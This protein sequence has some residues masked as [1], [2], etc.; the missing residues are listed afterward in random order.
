MLT[1]DL[2]EKLKIVPTQPGVYLWKDADGVVIYVG[3]AKVLRNRVRSYHQDID[4]KDIKTR[5]M[6]SRAVDLDWMVTESEKAALIL[7]NTLIKKYRPR[8]N[9]LLRDDKNFLSIKLTVNETWPRL[10]LVRR[11]VRD[12]SV[13]FGPFSD[14]GAARATFGFLNRHFPLRECSDR[15]FASRERPCINYQIGRSAGPC[16]GKIEKADYDRIVKQVRLFFEG[17][18]HDL[19]KDLRVEMERAAEDLRFEQAARYRDLVDALTKTLNKQQAEAPYLFDRDDFGLYREGGNG[20][21]LVCFV[22]AGKIIGQR[23]FPFTQQEG[24]DEEVIAQIVQ[25]YYADE[26]VVP[27]EVL[28]PFRLGDMHETIEEW[29]GDLRGAKVRLHPPQ[30]GDKV[31]SVQLAVENARQQF[32]LRRQKLADGQDVLDAVFQTLQLERFPHVVECFDISNV[33]GQNAVASQVTFVGGRPAKDRYKRY[34]IRTKSTPDDYAMM[35]EALTRRIER[36]L[37]EDDWP[38]LIFVDGGRGQLAVARSVLEDRGLKRPDLAAI[39]KIREQ[40]PANP[41]AEDM[42]YI[43][44]RKNPI[45]F[46]R[47]STTLFFIQRVRDEAHRF[48]LEYHR[49]LRSRSQMKSVLDEVSGV[50][51]TRKKALIAHFGSL[52]KMREAD[53]ADIAR[54]PGIGEETARK[55][56]EALSGASHD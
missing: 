14:A 48:A 36:A 55:I 35:R 16:C 21:V 37:R 50:G 33:Q 24:D 49:M 2:L 27:D 47:G 45:T 30:R 44:G 34:K 13:Y 53:F 52:K 40:D 23:V 38:D 5:V 28:V 11:I 4:G 19:I 9:I 7:E 31:V 18:G 6:V 39:T 42:V 8:F 10:Y 29:L 20:V 15:Q 25:A 12:G 1:H 3:K 56:V 51:K 41:G 43:P 32:E 22:R 46:K 17:R 54:V 26:N